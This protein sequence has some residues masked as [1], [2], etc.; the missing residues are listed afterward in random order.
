MRRLMEAEKNQYNFMVNL[1]R[2]NHDFRCKPA[3]KEGHS[4]SKKKE[5]VPESDEEEVE[6]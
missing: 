2:Q 4:S 5:E 1:Q 3:G 6:E